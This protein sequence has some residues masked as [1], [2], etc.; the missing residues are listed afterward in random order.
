M[1]HELTFVGFGEDETIQLLRPR[2]HLLLNPLDRIA[3]TVA[4]LVMQRILEKSLAMITRMDSTT[5][6]NNAVPIHD[7]L[8]ILQ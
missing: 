2:T 1:P 6:K 8:K 3:L 5:P 4:A 7:K